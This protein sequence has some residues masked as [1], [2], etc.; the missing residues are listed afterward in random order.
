ML[1]VLKGMSW[2]KV[3]YG[4]T[5]EIFYWVF[6]LVSYLEYDCMQ[7]NIC[8][9][10]FDISIKNYY[11]TYLVSLPVSIV[12]FSIILHSGSI[13]GI[14][15]LENPDRTGSEENVEEEMDNFSAN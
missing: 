3:S 5:F 9:Q 7:Q 4:L 8:N 15:D 11:L 10:V 2:A 12:S 14:L 6:F 13:N 1:R